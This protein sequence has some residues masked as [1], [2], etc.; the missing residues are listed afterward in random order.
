MFVAVRLIIIVIQIELSLM[1]MLGTKS[2]T[3]VLTSDLNLEL[4]FAYVEESCGSFP[5]IQ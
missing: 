2:S 1:H 5:S 4:L 3:L